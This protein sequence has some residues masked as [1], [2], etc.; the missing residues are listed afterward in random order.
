[1]TNFIKLTNYEK[2]TLSTKDAGLTEK[3]I[4]ELHLSGV[5]TI[6]LILALETDAFADFSGM[7][8]S[9]VKEIQGI[10]AENG[11]QMDVHSYIEDTT[12][13]FEEPFEILSSILQEEIIKHVREYENTSG[14]NLVTDPIEKLDMNESLKIRLTESNKGTDRTMLISMPARSIIDIYR[15]LNK[16]PIDVS[17]IQD[18][19][20]YVCEIASIPMDI[21]EQL[22]KY[23]FVEKVCG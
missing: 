11:L 10:L 13:D 9:I 22:D 23:Y 16:K 5:D 20:K 12:C 18:F 14:I 7:E 17:L 6:G 8:Y 3:H 15:D 4:F 1:M 21:Y 19:R 2:I